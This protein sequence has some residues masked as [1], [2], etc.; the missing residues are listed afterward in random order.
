M[1]SPT[2]PRKS[3]ADRS[4][5][6][7]AMRSKSIQ[8]VTPPASRR[9]QA[10]K[11]A[12]PNP[13]AP[14]PVIIG[15]VMR[16]KELIDLVV[17]RSGIKK[18]DAKPVVEAMLSVLGEALGDSRELNLLP[19]GKFKVLNEKDLANGKMMRVKVRQVKTAAAPRRNAE[20]KADG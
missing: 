7:A 17:E 19:M 18:K 12:T 4:K 2:K 16:K 13:D 10:T 1:S 8:T 5:L 9:A 11:A 3:T 6:P 14:R 20:I 15:P